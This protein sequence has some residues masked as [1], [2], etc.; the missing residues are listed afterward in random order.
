M[1]HGAEVLSLNSPRRPLFWE[2]VEGLREL[3]A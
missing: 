3:G 1:S 2:R